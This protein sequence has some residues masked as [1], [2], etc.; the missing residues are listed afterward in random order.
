[1]IVGFGLKTSDDVIGTVGTGT[2]Q[3]GRPT[4]IPGHAGLRGPV[5]IGPGVPTGPGPPGVGMGFPGLSLFT[6]LRAL[7][8]GSTKHED[9]AL[10]RF[11][12]ILELITCHLLRH[13]SAEM[14]PKVPFRFFL[15]DS[16][17]CLFDATLDA[18]A[19]LH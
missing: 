17:P 1:M 2:G 14:P 16:E 18:H 4:Q 10:S 9:H 19:L 5:I 11:S 12:N 8:T 3:S 15:F 13:K 7:S 6:P